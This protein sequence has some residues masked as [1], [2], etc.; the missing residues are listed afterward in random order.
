MLPI[1]VLLELSAPTKLYPA[2]LS[3]R[4]QSEKRGSKYVSEIHI[5][6]NLY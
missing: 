4:L 2:K 5:I 6:S 3:V 1:L